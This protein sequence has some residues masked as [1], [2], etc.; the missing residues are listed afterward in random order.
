MVVV[1][2][3]LLFNQSY[4]IGTNGF[5][6]KLKL[7]SWN[8]RGLN[9]PK[10][11]EVLKNWLRKWKVDVVCLQE[12]KLDRVD[13][14]IIQ[15]IWGNRFVGWAAPNAVNTVGGILLLWDK[16]VLEMTDSRVGSFLVSCCWKG[17][18]DGFEWVGS[19]VWP[20]SRRSLF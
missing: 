16:R 18:L 14:R 20:E 6:M 11:R 19:G 7:L 13:W 1:D 10:K 17:L 8:V 5:F 12:T 2:V 4:A 15:S 3:L 9:D